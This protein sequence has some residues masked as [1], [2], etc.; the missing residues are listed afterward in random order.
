MTIHTQEERERALIAG[1]HLGEVLELL[2]GEV[3]PGVSTNTLEDL[4]NKWIEERGGSTAFKGYTPDGAPRPYPATLCVSVNDEV[5]HGIPNEQPRTLAEGDIITLDLGLSHEGFIVDSALTVAVGKTDQRS[6]EL[7]DATRAALEAGIAAA[8][9]GNRI[10]DIS[11]AI[12]RAYDGSGF[13]IVKVLGGHGVGAHVHEEPWIANV[14]YPGTGVEIESG[15]VLAL[16]PIANI[17]KS[18]VVLAPD[19][20]TYRTKDG[21]RSAHFEHTILVESSGTTVL[22]RRPSEAS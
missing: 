12:E 6:Y 8:K 14:G 19:G 16:E 9:A 3:K 20:Y 15:M 11:H 10:G 18:A 4:A 1:K 17:G 13:S 5:V 22:T 2:A 21:S 7:M